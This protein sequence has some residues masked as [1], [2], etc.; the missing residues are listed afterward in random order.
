MSAFGVF[1]MGV[2]V[3]GWC[4]VHFLWQ[5]L[6]I[7]FAYAIARTLLPRG[8]PRY[9]ASMLALLALAACPV[10]TGLHEW[11]AFV[12]PAG[13]ARMLAM[14]PGAIGL[15]TAGAPSAAAPQ[16]NSL[17]QASLPWLVLAW[18][19]GVGVLATR[20]FRQWRGLRAI[21]R[22]AQALPAWQAHARRL[23][24]RFGLGRAVPVLSSLRVG[25]PTLIGWVRP[26]VVLPMAVL[27][28]MSAEQIEMVLAHELA[29]LK[30]FDHLANLFQL[31]LETVLFYHPVVHWISRDA[32]RERELC[33]D[34]LALRVTAGERRDF[35]AALA[36]LAEFRA[37]HA[38]LVLAASG[39][40]L[41]ERAWFIARGVHAH[42]DRRPRGHAIAVLAAVALLG[43]GWIGWRDAAWQARVASIVAEQHPLLLPQ[44]GRAMLPAWA[45]PR[46]LSA[47]AYPGVATVPRSLVAVEAATVARV[48]RIPIDPIGNPAWQI[49]AIPARQQPIAGPGMAESISATDVSSRPAGVP[50]R[51]LHASPPTYPAAAR[52]AGIQGQVVVA[53]ALDSNGVPR[54]LEVASSDSGMLD[55][56]ALQA[57]SRWRFAPPAAPG[58]RYR[59]AFDFRLGA[60]GP[61]ND[62]TDR[63]C[64]VSTGTHICRRIPDAGP[65]LRVLQPIP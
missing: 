36:N 53:F 65:G 34:A 16:W 47:R 54:D 58:E 59:Q 2:A 17:L 51:V 38:G 7:G 55:A 46:A 50:P 4:L 44:L 21:L 22:E 32:R 42:P 3:L 52:L 57:L 25:A 62:A 12:Q 30:R 11:R 60:A 13:G 18:A 26:V 37:A 64:T 48:G 19:A 29:H 49:E 31:V 40:V 56:A 63:Q 24:T 8:N 20:V 39:G 27:A 43:L 28:R 33:C 10:A 35:V 14:A 6:A 45:L 5:A 61:A 41:A 1:S 23:A 9:L 15:A